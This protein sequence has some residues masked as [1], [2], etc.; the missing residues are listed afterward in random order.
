M[1]T[2]TTT[3]M[4]TRTSIALLSSVRCVN[5]NSHA[6]WGWE[7]ICSHSHTQDNTGANRKTI[8]VSVN[9]LQFQKFRFSAKAPHTNTNHL[10]QR[11]YH[12]WPGIHVAV[13]NRKCK[14]IS[15]GEHKQQKGEILPLV[16]WNRSSCTDK[17]KENKRKNPAT[18]VCSPPRSCGISELGKANERTKHWQHCKHFSLFTDS[19]VSAFFVF[20]FFCFIPAWRFKLNDQKFSAVERK[21]N[22]L[23]FIIIVVVVVV[24]NNNN[25]T[26]I[27]ETRN[28]KRFSKNITKLQP[29]LERE[30]GN[31]KTE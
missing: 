23:F 14:L 15:C 8:G 20:C 13:C 31:K 25:N 9:S 10:R 22:C 7:K 27:R 2:T 4:W 28:G 30:R 17:R 12:P 3:T 6:G 16:T 29:Y 19:R 5:N 11:H 21:K 18:N 26:G 1:A 24:I